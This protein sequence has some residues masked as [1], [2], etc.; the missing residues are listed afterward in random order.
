MDWLIDEFRWM[1]WNWAGTV[2]IAFLILSI[3]CLTVWDAIAPGVRKKGFLPIATTR[4]DRLFIG[5]MS[6]IG[7]ILIWLALVGNQTLWLAFAL[8]AGFNFL[9]ALRG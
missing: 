6:S 4:G 8:L 2:F 5:I 3:T 9:L 7:L 1:Q